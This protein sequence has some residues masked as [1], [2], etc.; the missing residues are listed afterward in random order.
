MPSPILSWLRRSSRTIRRPKPISRGRQRLLNLE[1][2]EARDVPAAWTALTSL[3][4]STGRNTGAGSMMLLS[5]GTVLVHGGHDSTSSNWFELTPN[6]SGSYINGT[7]TQVASSNISRLFFTSDMLPNGKV[8]VLG[9]EYSND[10]NPNLTNGGDTNSGEIYDPVANTWTAIT[11]FPKPISATTRR[12]C[13]RM[14]AC[15]AGISSARSP[16][17]G[18]PPPGTTAPG[19]WAATGNKIPQ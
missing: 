18:R 13:W 7:F 17:S 1:C 4:P 19:T 14:G 9:G 5:D 10:P 8:L 15:S 2:L 16:I 12:K 6:A 3:V 11:N